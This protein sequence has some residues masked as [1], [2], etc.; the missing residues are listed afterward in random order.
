MFGKSWHATFMV[1]V[2]ATTAVTYDGDSLELELIDAGSLCRRVRDR[3]ILHEKLCAEYRGWIQ[4]EAHSHS[5]LTDGIYCYDEHA[6]VPKS[7]FTFGNWFPIQ[8][9]IRRYATTPMARST[10]WCRGR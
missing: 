6:D 8:E 10:G 2:A 5:L 3:S 9:S 4:H 1:D 7:D